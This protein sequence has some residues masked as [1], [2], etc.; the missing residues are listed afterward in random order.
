MHV[1]RPKYGLLLFLCLALTNFLSAQTHWES[2]V[3]NG[4][5]YKYLRASANPASNWYTNTFNDATWTSAKS[6]IGF[7]YD[8]ST[9]IAV[10]RAVYLRRKFTVTDIT[11][12]KKL[13]FEID[14]DD[15]FVAYLNGVEIARSANIIPVN[16]GYNAY[17]NPGRAA[18][19]PLGKRPERFMVRNINLIKGENQLAVQVINLSDTSSTL[20]ARAWLQAEILG[21]ANSY[22]NPP[23]WF[24]VPPVLTESNLPILTI[25]TNGQAIS[26]LSKIT[27]TMGI[28]DNGSGVVNHMTDTCRGYNGF[29]GIK[30]RGE[31]SLY[32][33]KNNY[34]IETRNAL[35]NNLNVSLLNLSP[36]NDWVLSGPYSDK[37]LVRNALSF[38][39]AKAAKNWNP[40]TR[41]CELILNGKYEG[42]YL[43]MEKIKKDSNRVD[44]ADL[45]P[46]DISGDELTG[47]YILRVDKDDLT[48]Q[49][50][51]TSV[52]YGG[53]AGKN[54]QFFEPEVNKLA[55]IQQTYMQYQMQAFENAL[56]S[57]AFA[58]PDQGYQKFIDA[59]SFVDY[60]LLNELAMD[61]DNFKYS[62]YCYKEKDSKGGK[63]FAGPIW[64]DDLG[65]GNANFWMYG[66]TGSGWLYDYSKNDRLFWWKRLMEETYFKN[67]VLTRWTSLRLGR[68]SN[69]RLIADIDSMVNCMGSAVERNYTQWPV[70][71]V[72]VWPNVFVGDTYVSDLNYLKSWLISRLSWM[73]SNLTGNLLQPVSEISV[74]DAEGKTLTLKLT[75]D[76]FNKKKL[77][78]KHFN[79]ADDAAGPEIDTVLY[80][81]ASQAQVLLKTSVLASTVTEGLALKVDKDVLNSFSNLTSN[82][83][84]LNG[85]ESPDYRKQTQVFYRFGI[86]NIRTQN[87]EMLDQELMLFN[88]MGQRM[89]TY[90]L[91]KR[92]IQEISVPLSAGHYM[93]RLHYEQVPVTINLSVR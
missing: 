88:M 10:C 82:R 20:T 68:W 6:S 54:Y 17:L 48:G 30:K 93:L 42:V 19:M 37:S 34:G 61:V 31:S 87:P 79:W 2:L 70:L 50:F 77:T 65:Y 86:L 3:K 49:Y 41:F 67:L 62:T 73:D 38:H 12:I 83:L 80:Q 43:L 13:F 21:T 40:R 85:L 72:H 63:I 18:Q 53:V 59:G 56:T 75:Q 57:P 25:A 51:K 71:G 22:S 84:L 92:Q 32:F 27:A 69:E 74:V 24:I 89:G 7:G 52:T 33:A 39:L 47:G 90:Q 29:I 36:E 91:E 14:Y 66:S 11:V 5:T 26:A 23:T 76:Y 58:D 64:D 9:N 28:V 78:N 45:L 15:A 44:I 46:A 35:G 81:N 55:P 8:D 16:P 1:S 60:L 4:D